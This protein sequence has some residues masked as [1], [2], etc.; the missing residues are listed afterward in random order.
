MCLESADSRAWFKFT[1]AYKQ[2]TGE[3]ESH[4]KFRYNSFQVRLRVSWILKYSPTDN[5]ISVISGQ[6]GKVHT[7]QP[8]DTN[9]RVVLEIGAILVRLLKCL[10]HFQSHFPVN[11]YCYNFTVDYLARRPWIH[12][13]VAGE[14]F[15]NLHTKYYASVQ[16]L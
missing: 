3:F 15:C 4:L 10:L 7:R 5:S 9:T 1:S 16:W 14:T 13:E 11:F 2:L 8:N 12:I 6:S